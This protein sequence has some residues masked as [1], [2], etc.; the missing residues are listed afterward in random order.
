M[1]LLLGVFDDDV[2][3]EADPATAAATMIVAS[4]IIIIALAHHC[5]A[6]FMSQCNKFERIL[7]GN[8]YVLIRGYRGRRHASAFCLSHPP[9]RLERDLI[10]PHTHPPSCLWS[11]TFFWD[12]FAGIRPFFVRICSQNAFTS[13]PS[14]HSLAFFMLK[15]QLHNRSNSIQP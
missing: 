5:G 10:H 3:A 1:L 4:F 6:L 9:F 11:S 15:I 2:N 12:L 14:P 7:A 13:S 8:F